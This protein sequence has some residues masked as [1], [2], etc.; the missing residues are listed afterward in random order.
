LTE[1]E[2]GFSGFSLKSDFLNFVP[3]KGFSQVLLKEKGFSQWVHL[4]VTHM[5]FL[6]IFEKNLELRFDFSFQNLLLPPQ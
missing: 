6:Q 3:S 4:A 2:E 1:R 5:A